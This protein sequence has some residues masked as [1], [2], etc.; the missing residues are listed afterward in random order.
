M[1]HDPPGEPDEPPTH[2]VTRPVRN[3]RPPG[4][5]AEYDLGRAQRGHR[6]LRNPVGTTEETRPPVDT[7]YHLRLPRAPTAWTCCETR[8]PHHTTTRP[9]H[10]TPPPHHA[11]TWPHQPQPPDPE[12]RPYQ[13]QPPQAP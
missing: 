6:G 12:R 7:H 11:S 2:Q 3:R 1:P 5:L 8:P 10:C 13:P 9:Q 4:Y